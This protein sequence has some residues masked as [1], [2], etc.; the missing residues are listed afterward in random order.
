MKRLLVLAPLF[1]L[2]FCGAAAA[3]SSSRSYLAGFGATYLSINQNE[4][5]TSGTTKVILNGL[6]IQ[7]T[8]MMGRP[9]GAIGSVTLAY[10]LNGSRNGAA[11]D[12]STYSTRLLYNMLF[13]IGY[14]MRLSSRAALLLGGGVNVDGSLLLAQQ[15]ANSIDLAYAGGFGALAQGEYA[16]T[17][18]LELYVNAFGGYDPFAVF[19]G[20]R[21]GYKNGYTYS[22]AAG[23][24]VL[25]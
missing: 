4:A 25:Y 3:Q 23:L 10:A 6:G 1:V 9:L 18:S 13:G 11:L 15:N 7:S 12:M 20:A 19:S 8:F 2:L 17:S 14:R 5:A 22:A 16:I 24:A 21:A